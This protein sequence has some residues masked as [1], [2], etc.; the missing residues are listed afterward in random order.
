MLTFKIMQVGSAN[1]REGGREIERAT[2]KIPSFPKSAIL[3]D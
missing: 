1:G 2:M 3:G